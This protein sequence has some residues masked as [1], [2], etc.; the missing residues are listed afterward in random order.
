MYCI[1]CGADNL[2][3]AKFCRKCGA[4]LSE[5]QTGGENRPVRTPTTSSAEAAATPPL[6]G[7][8]PEEEE[9]RVVPR[10]EVRESEIIP[11]RDELDAI[12]DEAKAYVAPRPA[13]GERLE[14][15]PVGETPPPLLRKEG[16]LSDDEAK[17]FAITPTLVFVKMGYVAA[18]LG[19][20]FLVAIFSA[21]SAVPT[22]IAV[23]I[24][25]MLF[26]IPAV[27]H[28]RRKLVRYTLTD[29]NLE[30]DQGLI[31][32]TT[33][34]VPL[35]RIQDVT[36]SAT[37]WQRVLGIGD[38]VIDNASDEGGKVVLKD[39][40]TPKSYADSLLKQMRRIEK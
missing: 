17:I 4:D 31:A 12:A 29:T 22:W 11:V 1:K 8:E 6:A 28:V 21:F 7:G 18:A 25:L 15:H 27:Y 23:L 32:R 5:Q 9:T 10:F 24:G 37:P 26:L 35:R 40:N 2:E 34:H 3:A 20:I 30:I 38:L 36:V 19:A 33:R 13:G 16:S 39:I 14:N